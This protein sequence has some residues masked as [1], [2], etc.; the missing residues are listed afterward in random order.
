VLRPERPILIVEVDRVAGAYVDGTHAE[1]YGTL[2]IEEIKI[3][4]LLQTLSERRGVV[5]AKRLRGALRNEEGRRD[6]RDQETRDTEG[7]CRCGAQTIE[8]NLQ[9][10]ELRG[11]Q[12]RH[13]GGDTVPELAKTPKSMLGTIARDQRGVDRANRYAGNPIRRE[14]GFGD[15]FIDACLVG[16]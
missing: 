14:T 5:D 3:D 9:R 6:A 11:R 13:A 16:P 15:A 10:I 4:K 12:Q 7:R 8:V 2:P 1:A